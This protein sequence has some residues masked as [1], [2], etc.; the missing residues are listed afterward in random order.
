[1]GAFEVDTLCDEVAVPDCVLHR[2]AEIRE[3]FHESREEPGPRLGVER[4]GFQARGSV[5]DVIWRTHGRFRCV[6][7]LIEYLDPSAAEGLVA[8]DRG[9]VS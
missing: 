2:Q 4:G 7:A 5:G 9:R 1:V 6:V 3:T 8:L